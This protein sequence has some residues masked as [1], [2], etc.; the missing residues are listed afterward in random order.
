MWGPIDVHTAYGAC[1]G[2]SSV[3]I[4]FCRS[5]GASRD[6]QGAKLQ[7][8]ESPGGP[9]GEPA[10]HLALVAGR[11]RVQTFFFLTVDPISRKL[12]LLHDGNNFYTGPV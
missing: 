10:W 7:S 12:V 1:G 4:D 2:R 5:E 9:R 8:A 6:W 3:T 11:W